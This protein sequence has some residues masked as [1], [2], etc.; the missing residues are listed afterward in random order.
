MTGTGTVFSGGRVLTE[1]TNVSFKSFSGGGGSGS[2]AFSG[3]RG[4]DDMGGGR[5]VVFSMDSE[6]APSTMAS[7]AMPSAVRTEGV[8][9][10]SVEKGSASLEGMSERMD[11]LGLD[12]ASADDKLARMHT[13]TGH[14]GQGTPTFSDTL[15]SVGERVGEGDLV[16][17]PSGQ[18]F[19]TG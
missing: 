9:E 4:G 8:T 6:P 16:S 10:S 19:S 12:N 18:M 7:T 17:Q 3:G 5:R 11:A 2:G 1:S 15:T 13:H 14:L